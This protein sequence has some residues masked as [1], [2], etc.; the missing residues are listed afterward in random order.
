[1]LLEELDLVCCFDLAFLFFPLCMQKS[2]IKVNIWRRGLVV[3][4]WLQDQEVLCSTPSC[5]R[6]TLSPWKKLFT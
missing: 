4:T 2:H 6:S 3:E 1:M 5:A